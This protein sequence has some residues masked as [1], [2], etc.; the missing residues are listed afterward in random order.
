M[1]FGEI[2]DSDDSEGSI[3]ENVE[4]HDAQTLVEPHSV[5]LYAGGIAERTKDRSRAAKSLPSSLPTDLLEESGDDK[6]LPSKHD[7]KKKKRP[8]H[9]IAYENDDDDDDISAVLNERPGCVRAPSTE[10]GASQ[11][12]RARRTISKKDKRKA[13]AQY[14]MKDETMP[15]SRSKRAAASKKV[16]NA[17]VCDR[18]GNPLQSTSIDPTPNFLDHTSAVHSGTLQV[19]IEPRL[20]RGSLLPK[21]EYTQSGTESSSITQKHENTSPTNLSSYGHTLPDT[22][23]GQSKSTEPGLEE[24]LDELVASK[25][26]K[27]RLDE[28]SDDE[29]ILTS[30]KRTKPAR[31]VLSDQESDAQI[32]SAVIVPTKSKS[33]KP[34]KTKAAQKSATKA[35]EEDG[36]ETKLDS[37]QD[38]PNAEVVLIH[39]DHEGTKPE[40]ITGKKTVI[41]NSKKTKVKNDG[42]SRR[43][44]TGQPC[45]EGAATLPAA[46]SMEIPE[47]IMAEVLTENEEILEDNSAVST[48]TAKL[49]KEEN[50]VKY[51]PGKVI[52][53]AAS[54]KNP[55]IT[56]KVMSGPRYRV[57]LS[58]RTRIDSLHQNIVRK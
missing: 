30:K 33:R 9:A 51:E 36:S 48:A 22:L 44:P 43:E 11:Q 37:K 32:S 56:A 3:I 24:E 45:E 25:S 34:R 13:L 19:E 29:K 1:K 28:V 4:S 35:A 6:E 7:S 52:N 2:A 46:S 10:T 31:A 55:L 50:S 8:S 17:E 47:K 27:R 54:G 15:P 26:P 40:V 58:K 38:S 23:T 12:K 14:E 21:Q 41:T 20:E 42:G 16:K 39:S 18:D 49:S 57:G 53:Y 5:E